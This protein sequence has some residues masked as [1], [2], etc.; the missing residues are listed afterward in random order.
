MYMIMWSCSENNAVTFHAFSI[1]SIQV[2]TPYIF[3]YAFEQQDMSSMHIRL[4]ELKQELVLNK[5]KQVGIKYS[6]G[7]NNHKQY[8]FLTA[9]AHQKQ[10]STCLEERY[11]KT[12][13]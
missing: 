5:I 13:L 10:N 4:N 11:M 8:K 9:Q 1:S 3:P 12:L 7:K 2:G 6:D